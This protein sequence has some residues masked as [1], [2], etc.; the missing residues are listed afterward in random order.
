M[1]ALYKLGVLIAT[2]GRPLEL[3]ETLDSLLDITSPIAALVVCDAS[4]KPL[5]LEVESVCM[6]FVGRLPITYAYSDVA[7]SCVQRNL[8]AS[9]LFDICPDLDYIQVLDDDTSPESDYIE[10]LAE[11]LESDPTAVGASGMTMTSVEKKTGKAR[12]Y[13]YAH[14]LVG[15]ESRKPGKVSR[16]GCGM[17]ARAGLQEPVQS[18]EW[19]FGC[20]L[21]RA[22]IFKSLRYLDVLP[23]AAL[24]EDTEFSIRASFLG[25]LLV[26]P[27]AVLN[28]GYSSVE[29]PNLPLYAH[30][31][32]RNRWF[33]LVAK[34]RLYFDVFWYVFSVLFLSAV[35]LGASLRAE[36]KSQR[37]EFLSASSAT[38]RGAWDVVLSRQPR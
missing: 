26:D 27:S 8:A 6:E 33:V 38:L 28:H 1:R 32:S 5:A 7:S 3:R 25:A 4:P 23:G 30:R 20:S 29:R 10:K 13:S 18:V 24:F 34:R 14:W 17:P 37:N 36:T 15:L 11:L 19:L 12:A 2:Y 35:Y 21:W 16:A 31:F 9:R 22:E